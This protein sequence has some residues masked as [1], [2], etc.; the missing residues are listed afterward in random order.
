MVDRLLNMA[1]LGGEPILY[2]LIGLSFLSIA[3]VLERL[4]VYG[5]NRIDIG[6]FTAKI[7]RALNE[8]HAE[9][10]VQVAESFKAAEA[11]VALEGL[12]NLDKGPTVAA[13]LMDSKTVKKHSPGT[14]F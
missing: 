2:L 12:T 10:A 9:G 8:G 7:V 4:F 1:L 6:H 5:R 14:H 11:Q 13:E 3:V